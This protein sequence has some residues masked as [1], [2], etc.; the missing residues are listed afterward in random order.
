MIDGPTA[1]PEGRL[2]DILEQL[3][4]RTEAREN[5]RLQLYQGPGDVAIL[6]QEQQLENSDLMDEHWSD[7]WNSEESV[8]RQH[9][10][11]RRAKEGMAITLLVVAGDKAA[12]KTTFFA[13]LTGGHLHILQ[14]FRYDRA[15][16]FNVW[17]APD[18]SELQELLHTPDRAEPYFQTALAHGF[19]HLP[20]PE[21]DFFRQDE[22]FASDG[23]EPAPT[24]DQGEEGPQTML[25]KLLEIG[26]DF[27]QDLMALLSAGG[28]MP[29][30]TKASVLSNVLQYLQ[31]CQSLAY[32]INLDAIFH[33]TDT[34]VQVNQEKVVKTVAQI[35]F[36]NSILPVG[37][38]ILVYCSRE[39][40]L[41]PGAGWSG[42]VADALLEGLTEG[43]NAAAPQRASFHEQARLWETQESASALRHMVAWVLRREAVHRRWHLRLH[44]FYPT[45]H[46]AANG[47][48]DY[49]A[50]LRTLHR[51]LK[52][53]TGVPMD[54]LGLVAQ[55][56]VNL[57][58]DFWESDAARSL[59]PLA[60]W[61]T[62]S[63]LFALLG[64][65]GGGSELDEVLHPMVV[66]PPM[67][68][69]DAFEEA[70]DFLVGQGLALRWYNGRTAKMSV[71][72]EAQGLPA[73]SW[74]A[75]RPASDSCEMCG[76]RLPMHPD[77]RRM[78]RRAVDLMGGVDG[79]KQS[80]LAAHV[81]EDLHRVMAR[82]EVETQQALREVLAADS[83]RHDACWQ[84]FLW[85]LEEWV[86]AVRLLPDGDPTG[87]DYC[88]SIAIQPP[89]AQWQGLVRRCTAAGSE[90]TRDGDAA[91]AVSV[92][93]VAPP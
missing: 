79:L 64:D 91:V 85:H 89:P 62:K 1:G 61:F 36:L 90:P 70:T 54:K 44:G 71:N 24:L 67:V 21:Y 18:P 57:A 87:R 28:A 65:E 39:P 92:L 82:L 58:Y 35:D 77:S 25:V 45:R 78:L 4:A 46:L 84:R 66:L 27:I 37:A 75:P 81:L 86:L 38:S 26:G 51:L 93:C 68:L 76:F 13:A 33:P 9:I 56:V 41:L 23:D 7:V 52:T 10:S 47:Q 83:T 42:P 15:S 34:A 8:R 72:V 16:F 80:A 2:Q 5:L 50:V 32:F 59:P 40:E 48:Y 74:V 55:Q 63:M 43:T 22:E 14:A 73:I 49:S 12:G 29:D 6:V 53:S 11:V 17:Y 31:Q 30:P 20:V 3:R 19:I 60:S 88:I 69:L